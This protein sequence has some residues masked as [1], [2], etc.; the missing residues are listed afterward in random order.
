[1]GR[2]NTQFHMELDANDSIVAGSRSLIKRL[3]TGISSTG[4]GDQGVALASAVAKWHIEAQG[5]R[6]R[7]FSMYMNK[8]RY[9]V[10]ELGFR[11]VDGFRSTQPQGSASGVL[12]NADSNQLNRSTRMAQKGEAGSHAFS[13]ESCN[14][15]ACTMT[16]RALSF[17]CF[18][19][20]LQQTR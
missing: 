12:T 16:P 10:P 20:G 9:T 5:R 8:K 2:L 1:M 15:K 7:Q 19:E 14:I 4:D 17:C 6:E 13:Q 3:S 11:S 18:P